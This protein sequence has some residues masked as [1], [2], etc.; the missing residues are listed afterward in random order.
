MIALLYLSI[1]FGLTGIFIAHRKQLSF[2][3]RVFSA[4]LMAMLLGWFI[5]VMR[6]NGGIE[7]A[8]I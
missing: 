4:L 5:N 1:A 6:T 8:C 2:S 7:E 3:V